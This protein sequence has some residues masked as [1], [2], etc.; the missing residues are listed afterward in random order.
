M[1]VVG[2]VWREAGSTKSERPPSIPRLDKKTVVAMGNGVIDGSNIPPIDSFIDFSNRLDILE[3]A[4]SL[5]ERA[6]FHS[7]R[8]FPSLVFLTTS[9]PSPCLPIVLP[10][11]I[12]RKDWER[13]F[14]DHPN[15]QYRR[16]V[17]LEQDAA[18]GLVLV[19]AEIR[20]SNAHASVW[21]Y[22]VQLW[23]DDQVAMRVNFA[24]SAQLPPKIR[25]LAPHSVQPGSL[26]HDG[27]F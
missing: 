14:K 7:Q 26:I 11:S 17:W 6:Q 16:F 15:Y 9:S 18:A 4:T 22:L 12:K 23:D 10:T 21:N 5:Y 3:R 25:P 8:Y 19:M 1:G 27:L 24:Q 20:E 13:W 2:G